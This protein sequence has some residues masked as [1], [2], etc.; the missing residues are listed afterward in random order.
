MANPDAVSYIK[1][2]KSQYSL[3]SLKQALVQQGYTSAEIEEAVREANSSTPPPTSK[4]A[5]LPIRAATP[6]SVRASPPPVVPFTPAAPAKK[7]NTWIIVVALLLLLPLLLVGCLIAIPMM[8]FASTTASMYH[9]L[10]FLAGLSQTTFGGTPGD[11]NINIKA[12]LPPTIQSSTPLGKD[13]EAEAHIKLPTSSPPTELAN[14]V[15]FHT[16]IQALPSQAIDGYTPG[17]PEGG[18]MTFPNSQGASMKYSTASNTYK[19]NPEDKINVNIIDSVGIQG[20]SYTYGI[21]M[22]IEYE[23]TNGYYRKTT[24]QGYPAFESYDAKTK[25]Y[26]LIV[27]L[28]DRIYVM[29]QPESDSKASPETVKNLA[30]Q[31]DYGLL[32][33]SI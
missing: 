19:A 6:L 14:A 2:Y 16:L 8:F 23:S 3:P 20:L 27:N 25:K 21:A 22:G 24:L 5:P 15:D 13:G 9:Y 10:P 31:V 1:Q 33:K 7:S 11:L 12:D 4:S 26:N 29:I 30:N 32:V 18:S 28:K 17:K